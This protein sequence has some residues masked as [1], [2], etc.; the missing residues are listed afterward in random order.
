[1]ARLIQR[2]DLVA[3]PMLDREQRLAGIVTVDDVIDGIQQVAT[4][5]LHAAGA[6]QAGDAHDQVQSE[7]HCGRS[8]L[9][10][11]DT[12]FEHPTLATAGT[13]PGD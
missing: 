4:V 6:V 2:Y 9:L 10:H 12:R 11:G 13:C 5:D 8:R 7:R 3:L 1:M